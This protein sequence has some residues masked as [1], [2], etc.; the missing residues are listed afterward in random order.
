[1]QKTALLT[2]FLPLFRLSIGKI[3]LFPDDKV[4]FC[5]E[6]QSGHFAYDDLH[7]LIES[8][9]DIFL[10]GTVKFLKEVKSPWKVYAFAEQYVRDQWVVAMFN[11]KIPDYCAV[12][13]NP[14][15]FWYAMLKDKKGCP[16]PEGVNLN[17]L[18]F[19]C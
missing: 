4:E 5:S 8:D 13:K 17:K 11:R 19:L 14:G 2:F 7:V 16:I 18:K 15:E 1:M 3:V 6:E 10:N 9:T 12:M